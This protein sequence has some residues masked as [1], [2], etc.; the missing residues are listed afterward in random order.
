LGLGELKSESLPKLV[1]FFLQ[2][3]VTPMSGF[4]ITTITCGHS[5]TVAIAGNA[6]GLKYLIFL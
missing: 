4:K 5:H 1:P 3:K 6:R 2:K